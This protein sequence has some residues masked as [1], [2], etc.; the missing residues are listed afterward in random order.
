MEL[1]KKI[2]K[3]NIVLNLEASTKKEVIKKLSEL[4]LNNG[5]IDNL[6]E[7]IAD[8]N[9]REEHMTTGIGN[10]LAIPHG[11]SNAVVESTVVFAK[12]SKKVE[13]HSLDGDPVNVVFLLAI[14]TKDKGD[15]HLKILASISGKLMDDNFVE[16]IKKATTKEEIEKLLLGI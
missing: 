12:L 9:E 5:F 8:V 14:A 11:K 10:E 16:A 7:F 3:E 6:E 15:N 1:E 13:W 2:Y 4:L